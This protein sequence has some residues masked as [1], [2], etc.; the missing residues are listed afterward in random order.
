M[1]L[2]VTCDVCG[3]LIRVVVCVFRMLLLCVVCD[4]VCSCV[5]V[6]ACFLRLCD[7]ICVI[8]VLSVLRLFWV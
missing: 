6:C 4:C 5:R 3:C 7:H 1:F 8:V 2:F